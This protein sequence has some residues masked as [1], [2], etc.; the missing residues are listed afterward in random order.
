[1][2]YVPTE[3]V[4][5]DV[6]TAVKL[7]KAENGIAAASVSGEIVAEAD[8]GSLTLTKTYAQIVS[9][10]SNGI[11]PWIYFEEEGKSYLYAVT[12]VYYDEDTSKYCVD[13]S[14]SMLFKTSTEDGY[15]S[16]SIG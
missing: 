11:L 15:P 1:M 6:I 4:T 2:A 14:A 13:N 5:G 3:W 8:G 16:I 10:I 9:L 7:N 12:S